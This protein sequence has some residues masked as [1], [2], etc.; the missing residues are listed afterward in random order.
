MAEAVELAPGAAVWF[1]QC[2]R[3]DHVNAALEPLLARVDSGAAVGVY[4][5]DSRTWKDAA[6]HG[7]RITP[8]A[9]AAAAADWLERGAR[10]V[11]G[12]CGTVPAHVAALRG[13]AGS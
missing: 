11:G 3:F 13:L 5:N 6:W 8:E 1:V 4:A 2:T 10:I 12:C 9:Y 7:E